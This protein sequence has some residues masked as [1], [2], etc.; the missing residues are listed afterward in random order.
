MILTD[1]SRYKRRLQHCQGAAFFEYEHDGVG[2]RAMGES[3]PL[4]TGTA[5]HLPL[6]RI[7]EWARDNNGAL[8]PREVVRRGLEEATGKYKKLVA[9]R[10]FDKESS[11]MA[12]FIVAEQCALVEGLVWAAW[13]V[14]FPW[15]L[16][17]FK[18]IAVER[19]EVCVIGCTCGIG[20][21]QGEVKGLLHSGNECDGVAV[22][23]RPD[24]LTERLSDAEIGIW[25]FKTNAYEPRAEEHRLQFAFGAM[26]VEARLGREVGHYYVCSLL[27]G[28]RDFA[29]K[30][31]REGGGVKKQGSILCHAYYKTAD[32]PFD[33]G[34]WLWEGRATKGF[35][36][37][38]TWLSPVVQNAG[39]AEG[40]VMDIMPQTVVEGLVA[41]SP[42]Y[43][44][45][46]R[47]MEAIGKEIVAEEREWKWKVGQIAGVGDPNFESFIRR[48][49]D[50][51]NYYG[52]GC[53]FKGICA[54]H[55]GWEK[56]E[57]SG[58]WMAR[59]PHHQLEKDGWDVEAVRKRGWQ[60][61]E[62]LGEGE[63][64]E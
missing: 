60:V 16:G 62:E 42:P 35:A 20:D 24:F 11:E 9:E 36:K 54:K 3:L 26:G 49:W 22:Q 14:F 13:R 32:P 15:L 41:V 40:L 2:L 1:R 55:P 18:V 28:K 25:D 63:G 59:V 43:Q 46:R 23:S 17:E 31:D 58:K 27:K 33:K 19:E 47:L 51:D 4:V 29:S 39:G 8:A 34:E 37:V 6:Q 21:G 50:C 45:P 30:E 10:G 56:P 57:M 44:L 61:V 52:R 64:E 38:P 53:E 48:S 5:V 12:P 7:L